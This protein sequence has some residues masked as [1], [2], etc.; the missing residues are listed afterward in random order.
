MDGAVDGATDDIAVV[1]V[2]VGLEQKQKEIRRADDTKSA[3]ND[4]KVQAHRE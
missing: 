2:T 3:A 4:G 1:G